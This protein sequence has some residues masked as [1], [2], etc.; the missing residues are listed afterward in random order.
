MSEKI[1]MQ[2]VLLFGGGTGGLLLIP[3]LLGKLLFAGVVGD[4][5]GVRGPA[6][7]S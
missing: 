6:L 2:G 1:T 3:L 5:V 7:G 4:A